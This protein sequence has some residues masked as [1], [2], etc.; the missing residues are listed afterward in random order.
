MRVGLAGTGPP[1]KGQI[2]LD[3]MLATAAQSA[4]LWAT[5][6]RPI[7]KTLNEAVPSLIVELVFD[8]IP[9]GVL[10]N[11]AAPEGLSRQVQRHL[12]DFPLSAVGV[13][14]ESGTQSADACSPVRFHDEE[15]PHPQLVARETDIRVHQTKT[16]VLAIHEKKVRTQAWVA[17]IAVHC[18]AVFPMYVQVSRPVLAQVVP[19]KLEQLG[20][21]TF[22]LPF[23]FSKSDIRH[24]RQQ[25]ERIDSL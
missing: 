1:G 3:A 2:V 25:G 13:E 5:L 11:R 15:L 17:K 21:H 23:G 9:V 19:I 22:V 20:Q 12:P 4:G 7:V 14:E 6:G 24:L 18:K 8:E 10:R 16:C